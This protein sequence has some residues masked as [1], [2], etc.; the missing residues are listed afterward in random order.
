MAELLRL[1]HVTAGYGE[2]VVLDDVSLAMD[3]G[4]RLRC[5]PR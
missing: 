3:E 5:G 1:E 4:D 2:G